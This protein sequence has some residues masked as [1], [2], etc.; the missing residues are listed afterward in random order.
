MGENLCPWIEYRQ[1]SRKNI[2]SAGNGQ[3]L[4]YSFACIVRPDQI[5]P[6]TQW[7]LCLFRLKCPTSS[8]GWSTVLLEP[9]CSRS[10]GVTSLRASAKTVSKVYF[11]SAE[12]GWSGW[13]DRVKGLMDWF[14]DIYLCGGPSL[15]QF[16]GCLLT[17]MLTE[18]CR[19]GKIKSFFSRGLLP[20]RWGSSSLSV[21]A[22]QTRSVRCYYS[23]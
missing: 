1:R 11:A 12:N 16:K 2:V 8:G 15:L 13:C 20:D 19:R 6:S 3:L 10:W 21:G 22:C 5:W 18:A 17:R 4:I 9:R 7:D 23:C 14:S